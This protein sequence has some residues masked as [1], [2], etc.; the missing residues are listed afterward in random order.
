[1]RKITQP[2]EVL[3]RELVA[4]PDRRGRSHRIEVVQLHH[5][6]SGLVMIA[7]YEDLPQCARAVRDLVGARAVAH[8]V[9]Q[10]HDLVERRSGRDAS[11]E[12]FQVCVDVA[13]QQYAHGSPD[14]LPIIDRTGRLRV[15]GDR[16]RRYRIRS[17]SFQFREER[18]SDQCGLRAIHASRAGAARNILRNP[19]VVAHRARCGASVHGPL[20]RP[21]GVFRSALA[22][23]VFE[24]GY[25]TH[26]VLIALFFATLWSIAIRS[27]ARIRDL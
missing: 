4:G 27:N 13:E 26:L 16:R 9:P 18:P 10:I 25:W 24:Y 7:P 12:G 2:L 8:D 1:M 6:R 11:I 22:R 23:N 14:K 3:R 19:P 15:K 20:Q 5:S 17:M 21:R